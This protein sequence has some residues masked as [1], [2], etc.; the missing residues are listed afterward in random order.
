MQK[1][2]LSPIKKKKQVLVAFNGLL[3]DLSN[4]VGELDPSV[5]FILRPLFPNREGNKN[6]HS[7]TECSK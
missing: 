4:I 2:F 3:G 7:E 6:S 5:Q 1:L